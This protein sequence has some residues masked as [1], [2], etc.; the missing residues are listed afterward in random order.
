MATKQEE[1][2]EQNFFAGKVKEQE[3]ERKHTMP[4]AHENDKPKAKPTEIEGHTGKT[5]GP[6]E[7]PKDAPEGSV[8]SDAGVTEPGQVFGG[9]GVTPIAE[10]A[11]SQ[12]ERREKQAEFDEK[13]RKQAV[14]D[15]GVIQT[16]EKFKHGK[17]EPENAHEKGKHNG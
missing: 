11:E 10:W 14:E 5:G 3:Q 17:K 7:L 8:V 15:S 13:R 16:T 12:K 2:D 1:K 6:Y 4:A 9:D